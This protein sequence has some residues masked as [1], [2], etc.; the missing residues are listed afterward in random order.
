MRQ[1]RSPGFAYPAPYKPD[2]GCGLDPEAQRAWG[3]HCSRSWAAPGPAGSSPRSWRHRCA[4]GVSTSSRLQRRRWGPQ[5]GA[6]SFEA[7]MRAWSQEP[8]QW[9]SAVW[10]SPPAKVGVHFSFMPPPHPHCSWLLGWLYPGPLGHPVLLG[11]C[12]YLPKGGPHG[13][14]AGLHEL[15]DVSHSK[16]EGGDSIQN[17]H[18]DC[19]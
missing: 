1:T 15:G 2:T 16:T 5:S 6:S 14:V 9:Y 4:G 10:E 18:L 17:L 11:L 7:R 19:S 3:G 8:I 12:G 13:L